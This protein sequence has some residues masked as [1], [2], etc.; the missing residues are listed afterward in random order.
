M[1]DKKLK[2]PYI[3]EILIQCLLRDYPNTLPMKELSPYEQGIFTG[4]Q[5]VR[6]KLK[7]EMDESED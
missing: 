4:Q 2:Y 3:S 7:F 6:N 1:S 5:M